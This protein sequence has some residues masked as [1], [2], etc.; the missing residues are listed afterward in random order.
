VR[1]TFRHGMQI[2]ERQSE[3]LR[4]S[5]VMIHDA[6]H[7]AASAVADESPP[8]KLAKSIKAQ[9]AA[10]DID[11]ANHP[12][13]QP[14]FLLGKRSRHLCDFTDKLVARRAEK[15][16]IA[17]QNLDIRVANAGQANAD[18][19]PAGTQSRLPS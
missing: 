13:A 10:T 19:R 5:T 8:A 6:E 17:A 2:F 1:H 11:L 18:E 16:V 12:L 14:A 9:S 7:L 15:V 3:V 4:K